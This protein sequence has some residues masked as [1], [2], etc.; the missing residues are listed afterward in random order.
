MLRGGQF[1]AKESTAAFF[2]DE[3]S[4][5]LSCALK[6]WS[7]KRLRLV[8]PSCGMEWV[9]QVRQIQNRNDRLNCS[10]SLV[11]AVSFPFLFLYFCLP[12]KKSNHASLRAR[13]RCVRL[14]PAGRHSSRLI[15]QR[16]RGLF[17]RWSYE[18]SRSTFFAPTR[19]IDTDRNIAADANGDGRS[20]TRHFSI[21]QPH[22]QTL[23]LSGQKR[24][25]FQRSPRSWEV[26]SAS[27]IFCGADLVIYVRLCFPI[28]VWTQR[29]EIRSR[30]SRKWSKI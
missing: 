24:K 17:A 20:L 16:E 29:Q 14:P 9:L 25:T 21:D 2:A 30:F 3:D 27:A 18:I 23:S 7:G 4:G 26:C 19:S 6:C 22:N 11:P 15:S 8:V 5:V 13:V 1:P 28:R 12:R 10:Q